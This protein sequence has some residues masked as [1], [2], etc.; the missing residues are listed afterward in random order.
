MKDKAEQGGI[1]WESQEWIMVAEI[2]TEPERTGEL[3]LEGT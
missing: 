3:R 2:P 1:Q